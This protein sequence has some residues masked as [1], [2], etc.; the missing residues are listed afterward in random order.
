[1]R[2]KFKYYFTLTLEF[3]K[4]VYFL[5]YIY[6]KKKP[7]LENTEFHTLKFKNIKH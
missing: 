4:V 6:I 5:K 7:C 3:Y 2:L 1:M